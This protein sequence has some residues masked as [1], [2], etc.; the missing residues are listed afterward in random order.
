[1]SE[2]PDTKGSAGRTRP[3]LPDVLATTLRSAEYPN[4]G[5]T[6]PPSGPGP[7]SIFAGRYA[8]EAAI[9]H[10][11]SGQVWR[12]TDTLTSAQVAVKLLE[13]ASRQDCRR[14]QREIAA[15]RAL[16]L[17]GVVELLD[18]GDVD[19]RPFLVMSLI[20]G[21]P[22]PG[23][24]Q[25]LAGAARISGIVQA[26]IR[27]LEALRHVHEAGIVH[28]DLK[29]A[30]VLVDAE[31]RPTILDFGLARGTALG[32][33]ITA[34]GTVLGT[35]RYQA[36]EQFREASVDARADLYAVGVMLFEAL[37]GRP[38][39]AGRTY[40]AL[41]RDK[42]MRPA[43]GLEE[44]LV[45]TRAVGVEPAIIEVVDALLSREPDRRP[46]SAA[47][48]SGRLVR[49]LSGEGPTDLPWIGDDLPVRALVEAAAAGR[50]I[51][52]A[53]LPGSGRTR[54]LIEAV[55]RLESG[56][57]RV[58]RV[59]P[60]ARPFESLGAFIDDRTLA[61]VPAAK[62]AAAVEAAVRTHLDAGGIV[63][64]DHGV[65]V[66]SADAIERCRGTGA[67]MRVVGEPPKIDPA[68]SSGSPVIVVS[69]LTPDALRALFW[70]PDR[71]LH[72]RQDAAMA[73][74]ERTGGVPARVRA[75]L[76][77]WI[78]AGLARWRED[79]VDIDRRALRYLL[80]DPAP[81]G[82][83]VDRAAVLDT[84]L[85]DVLG[86]I[87][88]AAPH[89]TP[90]RLTTLTG[91]PAWEIALSLDELVRLG[92][93]ERLADGRVRPRLP[94]RGLSAWTVDRR[95][96]AHAQIAR[97]LPPGAE[98]RLEHLI[99][100]GED[101]ADEIM[102]EAVVRVAA[103]RADGDPAAGLTVADNALLA[104]RSLERSI[105]AERLTTAMV[106]A[107]IEA[108][109]PALALGS[110][111]RLGFESSPLGALV[112]AVLRRHN[113]D[114]VGAAADA[115][116]IPVFDEASLEAARLQ[117]VIEAAIEAAIEGG[118]TT[119]DDRLDALADWA[120]A[121]DISAWAHA[122]WR[123]RWARCRNRWL[124]A[125]AAFDDAAAR[126][127]DARRRL[128]AEL[129]AADASLEAGDLDEADARA[130]RVL[131]AA[132][133]VRWTQL[134]AGAE[135]IRRAAVYR[136]G[137]AVAVDAS[138]VAAADALGEVDVA[139]RLL[140]TESAVAWRTG[141]PSTAFELADRAAT[142]AQ[143][144]PL[145]ALA[146][147]FAWSLSASVDHDAVRSVADALADARGDPPSGDWPAA[148]RA[149][150]LALCAR[151]AAGSE[152]A[153]KWTASARALVDAD[154]PRTFEIL[155]ASEIVRR[156]NPV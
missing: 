38:P 114:A 107:A 121:A 43:P 120:S 52:V 41:M 118:T 21:T 99:A 126:A 100:A 152:S 149:Q 88:L 64:L 117:L 10:G 30:N 54:C 74:F 45:E 90:D 98:R 18:A 62:R 135:A 16:R 40:Q 138:L 11:G 91:L 144:A 139:A 8:L 50:A 47:E 27:L 4:G 65:D 92:A 75:E 115:E 116:A 147:A 20:D 105:D 34:T 37:C 124:H 17:P 97:A 145:A 79:K 71:I 69:A 51:D 110:L 123:G 22:Y 130:V 28:R 84:V 85:D 86:W 55:A 49:G 87:A 13:P 61:G 125:V 76:D 78:G 146:Q 46:Q 154:D 113:G 89:A 108:D 150:V 77:R 112:R 132:A 63:A 137:R 141:D 19:G 42:L 12:A 35:P 67:V 128:R 44:A 109:A 70:G 96:E 94:P 136:A 72:L 153:S 106:A 24:V 143:T 68:L 60:G 3:G 25:E 5:M 15:L 127:P 131:D 148:I 151:A 6:A 53:G 73:L 58:L 155:A 95:R 7:L 93:A 31:N 14:V 33:T 104:V 23:P 129:A 122:I 134:E 111:E 101:G 1:M 26:T 102:S 9:G 56:G 80:D 59:A 103:A 81:V 2:P 29:P 142:R 39:H 140:L 32:G 57:H 119:V 66:W 48:V 133:P 83:D 36:P 82:A 156:S